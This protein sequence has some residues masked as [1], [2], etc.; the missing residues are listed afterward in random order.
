MVL[1]CG[2][3]LTTAL[4]PLPPPATLLTLHSQP[5]Q[6]T[7]LLLT[8]I[9]VGLWVCALGCSAWWRRRRRRV[10]GFSREP[11]PLLTHMCERDYLLLFLSFWPVHRRQL[12]PNLRDA[13]LAAVTVLIKSWGNSPRALKAAVI[14][15]TSG[16]N[17]EGRKMERDRGRTEGFQGRLP[18]LC[19][20]TDDSI[21]FY[22]SVT[23]GKRPPH[24]LIGREM[25]YH[26]WF[27]EDCIYIT[28]RSAVCGRRLS[29]R[30]SVKLALFTF[31]GFLSKMNDS[32]KIFKN[33]LGLHWN[34][35]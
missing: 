32:S 2:T 35:D 23:G 14:D 18:A 33:D 34:P 4:H 12:S 19:L 20:A 17:S 15:T 22:R 31:D 26:S 10:D 11:P 9:A 30:L 5:P 6:H 13:S 29:C 7:G 8:G 3:L 25:L 1:Q 21:T 16:R 28:A 27:N 24:P